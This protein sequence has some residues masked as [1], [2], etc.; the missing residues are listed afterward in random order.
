MAINNAGRNHDR[1][2]DDKCDSETLTPGLGVSQ[3]QGISTRNESHSVLHTDSEGRNQTRTRTTSGGQ[4]T[5]G[6]IHRR[7]RELHKAC[8]QLVDSNQKHLENSLHESKQL[9]T[10]IH[11]LETLLAEVLDNTAEE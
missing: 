1:Q 7:L 5:L 9:T 4:K 6:G 10:E 3:R 8:L 2:K 11:D